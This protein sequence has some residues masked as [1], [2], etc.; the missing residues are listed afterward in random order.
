[1]KKAAFGIDIG[2]TYTKIGLVDEKGNILRE[3]RMPTDEQSDAKIFINTLAQELKTVLKSQNNNIQL[4][5]IGLGAPNANY[6]TGFIEHA[7]NLPWKGK[8][9]IVK[10]I[11]KHFNVP[12]IVTNDANAAAIGEMHFGKAKGMKDFAIITLGTGLGSGFVSNG[13]LIYGSDGFAGELGHT[14]VKIDGRRCKC[15]KNGC[16]E[17]YVSA[18]GI[19]RT[20]F[21]FLSFY[22]QESKLR[23]VSYEDLHSN[24]IAEEAAKGDFIAQ[25]AFRFTGRILGEKLADIVALFSP[26]AIF[27]FGGLMNAGDLIL[28]P[29]KEHMDKN[30]LAVFAN[31][32]KLEISGLM[33]RNAAVLGASA[34]I[35]DHYNLKTL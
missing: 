20:I 22:H 16:F 34:L 33:D 19:K 6:L 32:T 3:S 17:T 10:E 12:V 30:M 13:Q 21:E 15:G 24:M 27:L 2:G 8:I 1:M 9:E 5:G 14:R 7:P 23:S 31:K 25:E 4:L 18:T 29:T 26:E 28:N 11:Q 35:W